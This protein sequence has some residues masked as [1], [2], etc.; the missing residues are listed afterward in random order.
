MATFW[1]VSMR[2]GAP[3]PPWIARI[4]LGTVNNNEIPAAE[5]SA[6]EKNLR[7]PRNGAWTSLISFRS[8]RKLY[9][10]SSPPSLACKFECWQW[11]AYLDHSTEQPEISVPN[12]SII[13]SAKIWPIMILLSFIKYPKCS[14][15]I[16][17]SWSSL[18]SGN[19]LKDAKSGSLRIVPNLRLYS[20]SAKRK[21]SAAFFPSPLSQEKKI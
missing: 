8:L 18:N 21:Q 7:T 5:D 4:S 10:I 20:L 13:T 17:S 14:K 2:S 9:P 11:D 3:S 6:T 15:L 1:A 12:F 16:T 19:A